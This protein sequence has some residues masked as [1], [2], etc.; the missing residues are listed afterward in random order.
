[1]LS[2]CQITGLRAICRL[3]QRIIAD[4]LDSRS[5]ITMTYAVMDLEAK[6]MT[7]AQRAHAADLPAGMRRHAGRA[8]S[9][10]GRHGLGLKTTRAVVRGAVAGVHAAGPGRRIVLFTDGITEAMNADEDMFARRAL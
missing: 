2:L 3:R 9:D 8:D 1:M 5:F 10:G 4:N 7:Y 6:T